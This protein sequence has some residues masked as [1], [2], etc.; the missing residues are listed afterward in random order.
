M[1][2]AL[3]AGFVM[4]NGGIVLGDKEN[5]RAGMHLPQILYFFAYIVGVSAPALVPIVSP[6]WPMRSLTLGLVLGVA[7]TYSIRYYT[8]EHPFLLSDNRHYPFY[9]WKN[10]F[11]RHPAAKYLAIP[12]YIY[13]GSALHTLLSG[14][15]PSLTTL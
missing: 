15:L 14:T 9:L 5:H 3:F 7:M 4:A 6:L 12:F 13:A 2:V 10:F 11:R 1:V 8:V